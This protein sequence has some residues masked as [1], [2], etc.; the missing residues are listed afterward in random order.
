MAA[1]KETRERVVDLPDGRKLGVA[2]AG[3]PDGRPVVAC[4]G[5]PG[6]RLP[7]P[8][9]IEAAVGAG[10]RLLLPDRPGFGLSDPQ[11]GRTFLD[12]SRD[13]EELAAEA[14]LERFHVLGISS[15][16]PYA[17]ACCQSLSARVIGAAVASGVTP[18]TRRTLAEDLGSDLPRPFGAV[19]RLPGAPAVLHG[20]LARL[21]RR[22]PERA[23]AR[24]GDLLSEPDRVLLT[25]DDGRGVV[26][27]MVEGVRQGGAAWAYESRLLASPWPFDLAE[28]STPVG[29]WHG[30]LDEAVP[31]D[32][33]RQAAEALPRGRIHIC[34]GYGHL[35]VAL[36]KL[37]EIFEDLFA[38][39]DA[40]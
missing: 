25:G 1:A 6:S 35:G 3:P 40:G 38:A 13:V 10:V 12:W 36:E 24:I 19:L 39:G 9:A 22:A 26:D 23:A 20:V 5:L 16:G 32:H 15:G 27:S 33:A 8:Q 28:I 30:D 11:P 7:P 21:M 14:G 29:L 37:P 18:L 17:L 31:L 4:H 2:E 34:A